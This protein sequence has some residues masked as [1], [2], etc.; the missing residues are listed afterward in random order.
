MAK[1]NFNISIEE[2]LER[3]EEAFIS[4]IPKQEEAPTPI[5]KDVAIPVGY[6]L[7]KETKSKKTQVA[8][9]PSL[10]NAVKELADSKGESFNE[11]LHILLR[12]ALENHK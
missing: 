8:F 9:Q 4:N 3:P 6:R 1:K 10:F 7:A 5:E 12:E 11:M 2:Q